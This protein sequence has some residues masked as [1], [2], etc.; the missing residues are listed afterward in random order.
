M[1]GGGRR[2]SAS[3]SRRKSSSSSKPIRKSKRRERSGRP[4]RALGPYMFFCKEQH[5][6][7]AAD[8]P[9]IP[10]GDVGRI[11][12]SRWQQLTEKDKKPYIKKAEAD[13]KR[14]EKEMKRS[15]GR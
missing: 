7:I 5:A 15:K 13:K 3:R 12:G 6:S 10:F 14:Y 2:S 9:N 4:K 8:N 1:R 11:L